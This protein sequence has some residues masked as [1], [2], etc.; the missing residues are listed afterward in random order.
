MLITE[1]QKRPQIYDASLCPKN[2]NQIRRELWVEIYHVMNQLIPLEKL[3][4]IWKNIRDRYHK[5]KKDIQRGSKTKP[6]YRY[7]EMLQFLDNHI[8]T[9][10]KSENK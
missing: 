9:S 7:F 5:I 6:K 10:F 4:K 3:P 8:I 1:I 2:K